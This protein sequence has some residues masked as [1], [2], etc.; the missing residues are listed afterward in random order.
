MFWCFA[1]PTPIQLTPTE[2]TRGKLFQGVCED[3]SFNSACT[4]L[5]FR[6]LYDGL[7]TL[8]C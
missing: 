1:E 8:A 6:L 2:I 5:P 4:D 3:Q 7:L